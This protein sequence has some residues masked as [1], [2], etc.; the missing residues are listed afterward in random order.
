MRS[1]NEPENT[2]NIIGYLSLMQDHSDRDMIR[3]AFCLDSVMR[4]MINCVTRREIEDLRRRTLFII[5]EIVVA[6]SFVYGSA[7]AKEI[8]QESGSKEHKKSINNSNMETPKIDPLLS[9]NAVK[10]LI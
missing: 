3:L 1:N 5:Y 10:P 7:K 4:S 2:S 6:C 8:K 9:I